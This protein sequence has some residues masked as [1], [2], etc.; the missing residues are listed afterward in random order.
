MFKCELS[1]VYRSLCYVVL[2]AGLS[3]VQSSGGFTVCVPEL[4]GSA[5]ELKKMTLHR[6]PAALS[7]L[8]PLSAASVVQTASVFSFTCSFRMCN[9]LILNQHLFPGSFFV[10]GQI[11]T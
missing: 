4:R 3:E 5:E 10:T 7:L 11:M 9:C 8:S 1:M 6:P 2:S